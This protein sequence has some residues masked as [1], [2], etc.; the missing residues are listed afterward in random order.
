MVGRSKIVEISRN[1]PSAMTAAS[2]TEDGDEMIAA[3]KPDTEEPHIEPEETVI[4]PQEYTQSWD[5]EVIEVAP[6]RWKPIVVGALLVTL[7][8][9][10][11]G[12]W[13]WANRSE[14]LTIAAPSRIAELVALWAVPTSLI[15]LGWLLAMRLSSTEAR[16][17]GDVSA[18]LRTESEALEARIKTVNGEISLARSFLAENARELESVGRASAQ[19]LTEAAEQLVVALADSDQKAQMLQ[20]A[21]SAAVNNLELFRNHLPV[22]T[23]AAKDTTNQIGNAGNTANEQIQ[24]LVANLRTMDDAIASTT[25]TMDR[26]ERKTID[27]SQKIGSAANEASQALDSATANSESRAGALLSNLQSGIM[28][29]EQR[30]GEAAENIEALGETNSQRLSAQLGQLKAAVQDVIA[31]TDAQDIR[32]ADLVARLDGSLDNSRQ[33][34]DNLDLHASERFDTL[35]GRLRGS[36]DDCGARLGAIDAS[37]T[38]R[39]AKLAFAITALSESSGELAINLSGNED[40]ATVMLGDAEKLMQTLN[41]ISDELGDTIPAAFANLQA[42]FGDSNDAIRMLHEESQALDAQSAVLAKRLSDLDMLLKSQRSSIEALTE[43]SETSLDQRRREVDA[44]SASLN[45]THSLIADVANTAEEQLSGSLQRVAEAAHEA[46]NTSKAIIESELA[47]IG[48]R[49]TEQNRTLLAAAIDAQLAGLGSAVNEA[50]SRN[51]QLS[52]DATQRVTAQLQS[53]SELTTNLEQRATTAREQFG[54]IDD[55]AFA[56]RIALLTESLNSAAIDVAKILSNEVT[57]TAWAAYLKGDRGVFTRRA[58]RLL[59]SS[60]ARIIANHY[61]EDHEF[62]DHVNRYIHDFEAMMRVLLSTRDG[63]AIGVTLLSSDVGKLYVALAQA[64]DRLR[65]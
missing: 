30:I 20:T 37:A 14:L 40:R 26:L 54:G 17:F 7:F 41:S 3:V 23:S 27:T 11:T 1:V 6:R 51:L 46:A 52:E 16:R 13:G 8:L 63:N 48:E 25:A 31:T 43:N 4:A 19:R 5:D 34:L 32:V 2:S 47:D 57:D 59:D 45:A 21:S 10:W 55:E 39:I 33:K 65:N 24:N 62:R 53:V 35:V 50:I 9:G 22:V 56:R 60:E 58:V 12:F 44:L 42:R 29:V 61:D 18:L 64:I 38:D 15:A 36:I 28:G 49:L